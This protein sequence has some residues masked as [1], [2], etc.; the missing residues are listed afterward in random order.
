LCLIPNS[1]SMTLRRH[2]EAEM[3][4]SLGRFGDRRLEK[5]GP[6][7]SLGWYVSAN[8]ASASAEWVGIALARYALP[9]FCVTIG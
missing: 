6:A 7:C 9:G 3:E 2:S 1:E 5:G 4:G 8:R